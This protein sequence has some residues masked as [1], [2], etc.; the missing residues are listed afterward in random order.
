VK[1]IKDLSMDKK[2]SRSH[3]YLLS[4]FLCES[5]KPQEFSEEGVV[6]KRQAQW[7]AW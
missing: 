2:S 6:E 4:Q 3:H 1:N 5:T 7:K